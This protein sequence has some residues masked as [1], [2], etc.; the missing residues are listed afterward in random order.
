MSTKNKLWLNTKVIQMDKAKNRNETKK[1]FEEVKYF[2]QQ[3][4]I[5]ATDCK[6]S[7]NNVIS[8]TSSGKTEYFYNILNPK[9]ALDMPDSI[10][11]S[12]SDNHEI[13]SPI[14]NEICT[15]TN[16]L[17]VSNAAS[18]DNIPAELTKN[19]RRTLKQKLYKL[20]LKIWNKEQ[21]PTQWNEEII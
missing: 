3:Q 7:E 20:I 11:K 10:N 8:Q 4:T 1:L 13:P 6:D 17:K 21:L 12:L 16:T 2:N 19:G 18:S 9:E 15:I 5:L 14:Y